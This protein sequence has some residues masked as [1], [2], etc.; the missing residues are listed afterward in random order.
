MEK[1]KIDVAVYC[2]D[3]ERFDYY[4][5][6]IE[7]KINRKSVE[8]VFDDF[9]NGTCDRWKGYKVISWSIEEE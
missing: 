3:D 9:I 7:G 1:R 2:W 8:K 4:T 5:F 6:E